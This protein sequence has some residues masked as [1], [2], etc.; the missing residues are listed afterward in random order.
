MKSDI[1][2][3]AAKVWLKSCVFEREPKITTTEQGGVWSDE[4][5]GKA[6]A[7]RS[8]GKPLKEADLP[9]KLPH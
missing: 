8:W 6:G 4:H 3:G 7:T 2:A 9:V 1:D 5:N